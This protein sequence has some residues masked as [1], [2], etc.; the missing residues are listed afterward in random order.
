MFAC[1]TPLTGPEPTA[2]LTPRSAIEAA[3]DDFRARLEA[4]GAD[5]RLGAVQPATV[6]AYA[7]DLAQFARFL[8]TVVAG[9]AAGN[10]QTDH[11]RQFAEHL[12]AQ[13]RQ[14]RTVARKLASVRALF[15]HLQSLGLRGDN[16]ARPVAP[17]QHGDEGLDLTPEQVRALLHLPER[18]SFTGARN[19][20]ILELLYGAGLR[21]DELLALNLTHLEID[22]GRLRLTRSGSG[23][24]AAPLGEASAAALRQWLLVRAEALLERPMEQ[25]DAGAL[26]V[27]ARGRRLRPRT[28]QRLVERYLRRLE[29]GLERPA[30]RLR[31]RGP[32]VLRD[33]CE[34]HMVGAGADP[35]L[36]AFLLGRRRIRAAGR[37]EDPARLLA[38][39]RSAHP[40][41]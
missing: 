20:A 34:Q 25:V 19:R 13:G 15:R 35:G 28:V 38:R 7:T 40:R 3:I 4:P 6:K 37:T 18:D 26:F 16:P 10:V 1:I 11:V 12:Q 14:P 39:Y 2:S 41:A 27:S 8:H 29:Q 21:V 31:H 17:P 24:A 33:A 23:S 5:A 32:G 9:P 36:V 30:R 22:D